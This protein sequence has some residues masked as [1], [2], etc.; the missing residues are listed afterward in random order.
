MIGTSVALALFMAEIGLRLYGFSAVVFEQ[1]DPITGTGLRPLTRGWQT[2]EGAALVEINSHG[3]RDRERALTKPARTIRIALLGDSF[4]EA[5]QV[6]F[7]DSFGAVLERLLASDRRFAGRT[8][9]VLNFGVSGFG[10]TQ[11]LLTLRRDVLAFQPDQVILAVFTGND[12]S[13]NSK[14]LSHPLDARPYFAFRGD[15]LLLDTSF[16][17]SPAFQ[18]RQ[19][20]RGRV[21][22]ATQAH[23]RL[24]Q[25]L[26][27]GS[28]RLNRQPAPDSTE[29]LSAFNQP[30]LPHNVYRAPVNEAWQEAWRVTER[31]LVTLQ[32]ECAQ[33]RIRFGVVTLS[34]PPQVNPDS[35]RRHAY[36][37]KLGVSDLFYPDG[38]IKAVGEHAGFPVLNLA[39][40]LQAYAVEHQVYLHGLPNSERGMGHWNEQAHRLAA[41]L[42][43][44]WLSPGAVMP[45]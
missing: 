44:P 42:I 14:A 25:L 36:E 2:V 13:D 17:D 6:A 26:Y 43:A 20:W 38:R 32:A 1:P 9:E 27:R 4:V 29:P 31:L 24:V 28:R 35:A 15:D 30:G 19:S 12:I 5:R 10:T 7:E 18:A 39:P 11:E 41:E 45:N 16:L 34:N 8:V 37:Q 3:Y 22:Y 40:L 33:R 21:F 23:V